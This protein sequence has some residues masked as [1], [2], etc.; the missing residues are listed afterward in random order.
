MRGAPFERRQRMGRQGK[1]RLT[2][3]AVALTGAWVWTVSAQSADKLVYA[4]FE[5]IVDGRAV[6]ARGGAMQ[7]F[8]YSENPTR[9]PTFRGAPSVD[10]PG[11]ELVRIKADD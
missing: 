8:G 10:P 1:W 9:L 6:S 7:L 5:Q 3:T 4:D 2:V 11:P